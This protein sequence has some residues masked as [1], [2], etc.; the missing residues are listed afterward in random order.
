MFV[1]SDIPVTIDV[2]LTLL[3]IISYFSYNKFANFIIIWWFIELNVLVLCWLKLNAEPAIGCLFG[4][5]MIL[6]YLWC[7][8]LTL[9]DYPLNVLKNLTGFEKKLIAVFLALII[10]LNLG[11]FYFLYLDI[12]P[13]MKSWPSVD[14]FLILSQAFLNMRL[15][16]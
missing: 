2:A 3:V 14:Y 6:V 5:G 10:I 8:M 11:P 12:T 1:W 4:F 7:M 15:K 9:G 13:G 16:V